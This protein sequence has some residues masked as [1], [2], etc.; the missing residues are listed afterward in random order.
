MGYRGSKS[1]N[2]VN[3]SNLNTV[4]NFVKEQRADGS[5]CLLKAKKM[6][7]RYA[8]MGFERNYQVNVLSKQLSTTVASNSPFI[9][10]PWFWTG[11][12]DAEGSF[13]VVKS[14]MLNELQVGV[15]Y[16]NFTWN[17]T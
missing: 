13:T 2:F 9:I 4:T 5:W 16:L 12:T 17:Y 3:S 11:L 8:L 1:K 7:L 6:H 10:N 14:K 15:L